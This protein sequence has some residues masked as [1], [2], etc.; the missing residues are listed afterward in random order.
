MKINSKYAL[1]TTFKNGTFQTE[2]FTYHILAEQYQKEYLDNDE[3]DESII[4]MAMEEKTY[5]E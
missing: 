3:V 5:E 2:F 4:Y 1:I